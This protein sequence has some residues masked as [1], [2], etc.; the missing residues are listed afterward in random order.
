VG[1]R[2]GTRMRISEAHVTALKY[3]LRVGF[4]KHF[5]EGYDTST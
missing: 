2:H 1:V 5:T 4:P 3:S